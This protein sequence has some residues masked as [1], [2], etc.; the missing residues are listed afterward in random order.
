M[1]SFLQYITEALAAADIA[2][3]KANMARIA[4]QVMAK[5]AKRGTPVNRGIPWESD[6]GSNG[7]HAW[8]HRTKKPVVFG[9][10]PSNYHITQVFKNPTAFGLTREAVIDLRTK[11]IKIMNRSLDDYR[12]K[13][14]AVSDYRMFERG[15]IDFSDAVESYLM[16]KGWVKVSKTPAKSSYPNMSLRGIPSE[17]KRCVREILQ[18][19]LG[20]FP[21]G[22]MDP[23]GRWIT[24]KPLSTDREKEVFANG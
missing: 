20:N 2:K 13:L 12:A 6:S 14:E 19:N 16:G 8:W 21:I 1:K 18:W 4:K 17:L 23:T 11:D 9:W 7:L 10:T 15:E 24:M 22:V 5:Q 3:A